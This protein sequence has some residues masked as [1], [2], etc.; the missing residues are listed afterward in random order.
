M[1]PRKI[2]V[3]VSPVKNSFRKGSASTFFIRRRESEDPGGKKT[4]AAP[5]LQKE[6][7]ILPPRRQKLQ[8]ALKT[9][10]EDGVYE[11]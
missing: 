5:I 8:H 2:R 1:K 4:D 10:I 6:E 3:N 11:Q 7:C 9:N